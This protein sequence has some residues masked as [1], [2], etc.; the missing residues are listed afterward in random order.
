MCQ[1]QRRP[2]AR[3]ALRT[4]RSPIAGP[5]PDRRRRQ[6]PMKGCRSSACKYTGAGAAMAAAA[7]E[8]AARAAAA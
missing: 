3:S 6:R 2:A 1:P 4:A 5:P 8:M 7:T